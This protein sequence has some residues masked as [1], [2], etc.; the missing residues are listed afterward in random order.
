MYSIYHRPL[1]GFLHTK[2]GISVY[3]RPIGGVS[4]SEHVMMSQQRC[5]VCAGAEDICVSICKHFV[6]KIEQ[7]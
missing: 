3:R 7:Q 6:S 2:R 1:V 5:R 4:L